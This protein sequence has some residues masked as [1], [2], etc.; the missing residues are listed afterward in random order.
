MADLV[1]VLSKML[2]PGSEIHFLSAVDEGVRSAALREEMGFL[3]AL[4]DLAGGIVG[5]SNV[6]IEHHTGS[7]LSSEAV[8]R[9]PLKQAAVAI[10][11]G[12]PNAVFNAEDLTTYTEGAARLRDARVFHINTL[13]RKAA[14]DLRIVPIF[15][16]ILT[17]RLITPDSPLVNH[18]E[19]A[20][21]GLTAVIHRNSLETGLIA[22]QAD[23]P[24]LVFVFSQII[25]LESGSK[26][27]KIFSIPFDKAWLEAGQYTEGESWPELSFYDVADAMFNE[28]GHVL[29][30]YLD[31]SAVD[32]VLNPENKAR[33]RTWLPTDE[34]LL[35]RGHGD[36]KGTRGGSGGGF[37]LFSAT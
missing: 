21:Y 31:A 4:T 29:V 34:L 11:I 23:D 6:T 17:H 13:L 7:P 12:D 8:N 36:S 1:R 25:S 27:H 18:S 3:A 19:G 26:E 10:V 16:D 33:P 9:M 37:S 30:G 22:M 35:M 20:G 2:L 14:P 28:H 5:G 15:E 32:C 24:T